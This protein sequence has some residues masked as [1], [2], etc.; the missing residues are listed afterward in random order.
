MGA[1]A[2][3]T[4]GSRGRHA[5]GGGLGEGVG[6]ISD[7]ELI[8]EASHLCE[9]DILRMFIFIDNHNYDIET[10]DGV[11]DF[12]RGVLQDD[13]LMPFFRRLLVWRLPIVQQDANKSAG[14]DGSMSSTG[15]G[16]LDGQEV[17][18]GLWN[19]LSMDHPRLVAFIF[20]VYGGHSYTDGTDHNGPHAENRGISFR[21]LETMFEDLHGHRMGE[22]IKVAQHLRGYFKEGTGGIESLPWADFQRALED[23]KELFVPLYDCQAQLRKH[24]LGIEFWERR[25]AVRSE[26][27]GGAMLLAA[28][29][30]K[31]GNVTDDSDTG[32][33]LGG[34]GRS[35]FVVVGASENVPTEG[36][37][38]TFVRSDSMKQSKEVL[39]QLGNRL[40][41]VS[42]PSVPGRHSGINHAADGTSPTN[43][44]GES[45]PN[46][47]SLTS[48]AMTPP[49]DRRRSIV[50]AAQNEGSPR[51]AHAQF[52]RQQSGDNERIFH[53]QH[54]GGGEPTDR[55]VHAYQRQ[56]SGGAPGP[57]GQE[58]RSVRRLS[59]ASQKRAERN[60]DSS[61]N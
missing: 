48:P 16:E 15:G 45:R 51:G 40:R 56:T 44:N 1:G 19:F 32:R 47:G 8:L 13:S 54:S 20:S 31:D 39:T 57:G 61:S 14:R 21:S 42:F 10:H 55:A 26:V 34:P 28:A 18:T 43:A 60:T 11:M 12:L 36:R 25:E 49:S 53:K 38:S 4:G 50:F 59:N 35:N 58:R 17:I 27:L 46:G 2:S 37:R 6:P 5:H 7:G 3:S 23:D 33:G 24:L 52:A 9:G 29:T 22:G 30:T 41:K